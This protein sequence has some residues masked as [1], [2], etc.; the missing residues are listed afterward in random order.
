MTATMGMTGTMKANSAVF[1]RRWKVRR[2]HYGTA[3]WPF[4]VWLLLTIAAFHSVVA[5]QDGRLVS[6]KGNGDVPGGWAAG[7]VTRW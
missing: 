1:S 3:S 6:K 5:S 7:L 2:I 4:F